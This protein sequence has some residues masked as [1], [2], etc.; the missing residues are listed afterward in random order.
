MAGE[1][2]T[3]T[4]AADFDPVKPDP[5]SPVAPPLAIGIDSGADRDIEDARGYDLKDVRARR[6]AQPKAVVSFFEF[7]TVSLYCHDAGR[8]RWSQKHDSRDCVL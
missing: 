7:R 3:L 5:N 1:P 2:V 8:S 6:V 4:Q